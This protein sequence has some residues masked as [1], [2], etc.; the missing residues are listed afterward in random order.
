MLRR[1]RQ[2]EMAHMQKRRRPGEG[3]VIEKSDVTTSEGRLAAPD[4]GKEGSLSRS[5]HGE[6]GPADTLQMTLNSWPPEPCEK[7][8][9]LF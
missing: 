7:T 6:H 2:R 5:L 3:R 9:L 8:F 1:R 4:V